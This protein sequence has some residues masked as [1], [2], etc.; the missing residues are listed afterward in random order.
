MIHT[1]WLRLG[2]KKVVAMVRSALCRGAKA[3]SIHSRE[4]G[5]FD[6]PTYS[7]RARLNR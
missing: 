1:P 2:R 4:P 5:T 6:W 3:L 7:S